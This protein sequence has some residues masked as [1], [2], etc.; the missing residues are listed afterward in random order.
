MRP[1]SELIQGRDTG[2]SVCV[3]LCVRMGVCKHAGCVC[4]WV[5]VRVNGCNRDR[6]GQ[7][8]RWV[9]P[10][11]AQHESRSVRVSVGVRVGCAWCCTCW[12]GCACVRARSLRV[13]FRWCPFVRKSSVRE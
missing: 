5:C 4:A 9:N 11:Q 10:R 6:T 12:C 13:C 7:H 2:Q 8:D 3:C 1:L